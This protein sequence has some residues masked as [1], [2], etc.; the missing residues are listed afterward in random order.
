[1]AF[2]SLATQERPAGWGD[3]PPAGYESFSEKH[4]R[5]FYDKYVNMDEESVRLMVSPPSLRPEDSL[6]LADPEVSFYSKN[7]HRSFGRSPIC[8]WDLKNYMGDRVHHGYDL[9][10]NVGEVRVSWRED[11]YSNTLYRYCKCV[12]FLKYALENDSVM[13][14]ARYLGHVAFRDYE[15]ESSVPDSRGLIFD[16]YLHATQAELMDKL[17]VK[18]QKLPTHTGECEKR[19][20]LLQNVNIEKENSLISFLKSYPLVALELTELEANLHPYIVEDWE[21]KKKRNKTLPLRDSARETLKKIG[22]ARPSS[23]REQAAAAAKANRLQR[24]S[25]LQ[26]NFSAFNNSRYDD[27]VGPQRERS[28]IKPL[29]E[30]PQQPSSSRSLSSPQSTSSNPS[31]RFFGCSR[32]LFTVDETP[33]LG[34]HSLAKEMFDA[35]E[36][37]R[38]LQERILKLVKR[39][40]LHDQFQACHKELQ[41]EILA[42][43]YDAVTDKDHPG[44]VG[45][46]VEAV[47]RD[48]LYEGDHETDIALANQLADD[49]EQ[50]VLEAEDASHQKAARQ[51]ARVNKGT[52]MSKHVRAT[53][54]TLRKRGKAPVSSEFVDDEAEG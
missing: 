8:V 36:T 17:L 39:H 21:F 31:E 10:V 30:R 46:T 33:P 51:S 35:E 11:R 45:S 29:D 14:C 15:S 5:T 48:N 41:D 54:K 52:T 34:L 27:D 18:C 49:A 7:L 3:F 19:F 28:P 43:I 12:L 24:L 37:K 47:L 22:E 25:L 42:D 16:S 9:S 23:D 40:V 32:E 38:T 1:M 50:I 44:N 13:L 26:G 4:R 6:A 20:R 2:S 53:A